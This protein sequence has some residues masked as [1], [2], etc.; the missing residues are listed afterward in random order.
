MFKPDFNRLRL[1]YELVSIISY[2]S[3]LKKL[4]HFKNIKNNTNGYR[5]SVLMN[6]VPIQF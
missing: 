4:Y 2:V 6:N 1:F 3:Y 5:L